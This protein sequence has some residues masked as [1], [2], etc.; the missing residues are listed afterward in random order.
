MLPE[1]VIAPDMGSKLSGQPMLLMR[2]DWLLA[3]MDKAARHF[4]EVWGFGYRPTMQV[5]L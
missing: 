5:G 4:T 2:F 3:F 1:C